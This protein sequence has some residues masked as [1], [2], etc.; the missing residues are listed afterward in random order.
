MTES[1]ASPTDVSANE[2][3]RE[4]DVPPLFVGKLHTSWGVSVNELGA[5]NLRRTAEIMFG[6]LYDPARLDVEPDSRFTDRIPILESP[7][8]G[9]K[10]KRIPGEEE[11]TDMLITALTRE[12]DFKKALYPGAEK[13]LGWLSQRG[14]VVVWSAGDVNGTPAYP[15]SR[16]QLY[17]I[18]RSLG[19][20]RRAMAREL[21]ES[22]RSLREVMSL[23]LSEHK[24]GTV[25]EIIRRMRLEGISTV[26]ILED[27]SSNLMKVND[28]LSRNGM[29]T[30]PVWVRQGRHANTI[31]ESPTASID[32]WKRDYN[33]V[34]SIKAALTRIATL[35]G[36]DFSQKTFASI[37]DYDGVLSN[38]IVREQEQAARLYEALRARDL[39]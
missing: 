36:K 7:I 30:V 21:P 1:S 33:A 5:G 15:G 16:Q 19:P 26:A 22:P 2:R 9:S 4:L 10:P 27:Q 31:P 37:V 24:H 20:A 38:D 29:T 12:T 14:P 11:F 13:A 34:D 6:A 17:K 23:S 28:T 25:P 3:V 35:L 18:A 8:P 32:D 39:I